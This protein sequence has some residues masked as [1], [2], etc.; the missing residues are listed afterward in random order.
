MLALS[1]VSARLEIHQPPA[2]A[3]HWCMNNMI[4]GPIIDLEQALIPF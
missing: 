3:Q 1:I 2:P 4:G